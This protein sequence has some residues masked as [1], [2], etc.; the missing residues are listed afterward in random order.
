MPISFL[1]NFGAEISPV[2]SNS[3]LALGGFKTSKA[4]R[5]RP[6]GRSAANQLGNTKAIVVQVR[7]YFYG[8]RLYPLVNCP[9]TMENHHF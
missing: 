9:I 6:A 5:E 2:W 7:G 1:G 4:R 3:F 8:Y